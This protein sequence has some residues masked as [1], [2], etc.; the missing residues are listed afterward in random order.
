MSPKKEGGE[1]FRYQEKGI[2]GQGQS[3]TGTSRRRSPGFRTEISFDLLILV[4][5][6]QKGSRIGNYPGRHQEH[7]T[8]NGQLP[9]LQPSK[10]IIGGDEWLVE[11]ELDYWLRES[12]LG[13]LKRVPAKRIFHGPCLGIS[14]EEKGC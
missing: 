11:K 5:R 6:E 1:V 2:G 14:F 7:F 8:R 12:L 13:V 9:V 3:Q 10:K 4:G